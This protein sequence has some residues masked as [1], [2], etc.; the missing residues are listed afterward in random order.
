[1]RE[2]QGAPV[3][4]CVNALSYIIVSESVAQSVFFKW[5]DKQLCCIHRQLT[6]LSLFPKPQK[7]GED[8]EQW[9]T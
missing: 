3:S 5:Q 8:L 4:L 1:M 2:R 6:I 7:V 9:F